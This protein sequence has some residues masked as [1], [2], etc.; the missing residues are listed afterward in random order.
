MTVLEV[1]NLSV[2]YSGNPVLESLSFKVEKGDTL[3]VIGPNGAGKTV[4]FK[5]LLGL[6]PYTGEVIWGPG[7]KIG[8][9]PQRLAVESDL[10]VTVSEFFALKNASSDRIRHAF[11]DVGFTDQL[12]LLL[13]KKLGALSG[14]QFQRLLIAWALVDH[15][16][17][18]LFDEPTTG[19]DISA[20]SSIYLTLHRLQQQEDLT[21]ILI[22]HE[23]Q[24][25]YRYATN[26]L[27]LNKEGLCWGPPHKALT[28][29]VL[30]E[31]FGEHATVYHHQHHL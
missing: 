28:Q 4:L 1:K 27:C 7:T 29:K 12:P 18:L 22:S 11:A 25:V 19:V 20:E 10:P 5:A 13:P 17:V 24:V 26:V 9:V 2:T 23:L 8:Y 15:P 16:G 3:A 31:L 21:M 6:T 14:G 30:S